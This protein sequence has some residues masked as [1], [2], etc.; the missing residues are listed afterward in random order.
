MLWFIVLLVIAVVGLSS[1]W[2]I[3]G[4]GPRYDKEHYRTPR[5]ENFVH[6]GAREQNLYAEK[7]PLSHTVLGDKDKGMPV[8]FAPGY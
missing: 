7:I 1:G 8:N 2:G 6:Y 4:I 3:V 5:R